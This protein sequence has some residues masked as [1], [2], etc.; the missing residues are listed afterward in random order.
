MPTKFINILETSK[1]RIRGQYLDSVLYIMLHFLT[2][3]LY[4][5]LAPGLTSV[6]LCATSLQ[7]LAALHDF[8][9]P[10]SVPLEWTCWSLLRWCGTGGFQD[11]GQCYF[12]GLSCSIPTIVF[13]YFS[14]SLLPVYRLVL[15]G[16]VL[17]T[18]RVYI[19]LSKP[20]TADL[21]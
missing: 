7:N 6:Y 1:L 14:L 3:R 12:I 5:N 18:D 17:R 16:W 15:W 20:C 21:F 19:T 10:L 4:E 11:Q 9:S 8:C 2:L 13:C